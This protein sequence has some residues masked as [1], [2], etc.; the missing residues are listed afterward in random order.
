MKA[1]AG[2]AWRYL[3]VAALGLIVDFGTLVLLTSVLHVEYLLS[4]AVGF[5]AGLIVTFVLS[6]LWV[7]SDPHVR[8]RWVRFGLFTI[9][10]LVG[11]GILTLLMWLQVDVLGWHYILAKVLA[12]GVVYAWNFFARRSMYGAAAT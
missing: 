3:W 5:T 7:F 4:A 6:E 1:L 2:E 10:G 8:N 12:T 9:I 11:L